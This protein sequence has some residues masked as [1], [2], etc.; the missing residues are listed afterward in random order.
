MAK[1]DM[2]IPPPIKGRENDKGNRG[3]TTF[4]PKRYKGNIQLFNHLNEFSISLMKKNIPEMS[5]S[6]YV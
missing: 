1:V 6:T 2:C 4:D 5:P 3:S